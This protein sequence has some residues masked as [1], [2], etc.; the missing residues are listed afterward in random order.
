[1]KCTVHS[2]TSHILRAPCLRAIFFLRVLRRSGRSGV[3]HRV[4]KEDVSL[5]TLVSSS[6]SPSRKRSRMLCLKT[7]EKLWWSS[8]TGKGAGGLRGPRRSAPDDQGPRRAAGAERQQPRSHRARSPP[9]GGPSAPG[10]RH[11]PAQK[12][13]EKN[14]S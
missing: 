4:Q 11:F 6:Y 13:S 10:W 2:M 3:T 14:I 8:R 9:S 7:M 5:L 12:H 1:M